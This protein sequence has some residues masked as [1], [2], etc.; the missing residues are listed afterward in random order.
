MINVKYYSIAAKSK[1]I[2]KLFYSTVK[3]NNDKIVGVSLIDDYK[4][5][6]IQQKHLITYYIEKNILKNAIN[7]ISIIV[8][9][10]EQNNINIITNELIDQILNNKNNI[11][12]KEISKTQFRS[13]I[14]D[15]SHIEEF[16]VKTTHIDSSDKKI[17]TLYDINVDEIEL[18]KQ[19]N[20]NLNM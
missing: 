14:V 4:N 7:K 17:I 19:L 5:N 9:K 3:Q 13:I 15:L 6:N 12:S 10:L 1:R 16:N 11:S 8:D 2:T 20:I 18:L